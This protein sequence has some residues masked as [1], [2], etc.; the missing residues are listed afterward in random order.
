E[1]SY[2]ELNG[3]PAKPLVNRSINGDLYPPGSVFKVV[4]AA[5][6]L[7]T[8]DYTED[9][10]V[11]GPAI[12]DLPQTDADLPNAFD[13][14]CGPNDEVTMTEALAVSCNTAFASIGMDIG[15]EALQAQAAKFGFG[16]AIT[17]P[18]RVTPSTVP[19]EMNQP[20]LAQASIGQYDVRSTPLQM[21]MVAA[22][23]ANQGAVMKPYLVQSVIGSDLSVIESADPQ[24][25]SQ[26]V[27]PEVA[28]QLTRMMEAVVE[29]GSG[30]RAQIDG[31]AVAGKT[32]T[33]QHGE[34][35]KAHAWF[36][37]F[38]PAD[39]PQIAV[40]VIA[41]DGGV[42][43]SEAGGGAVAAPIAKRMM[44]ARLDR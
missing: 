44:E 20:Q 9:T 7:S 31:V 18:M 32:G 13:G 40:A 35:R 10:V 36:I 37:S 19:P 4:T 39:D 16:D 14:P 3:D 33:A 11:P 15:T 17:I 2:A 29:D 24:E 38:A 12:L 41:E 21:A 25:L 42:A 22:G 1:N 26:A 5:A 23:V 27:T 8:G 30:R 28:A 34:G 6:A 43:G